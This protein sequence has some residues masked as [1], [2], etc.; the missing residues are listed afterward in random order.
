MTD[1]I[2]GNSCNGQTYKGRVIT[3]PIYAQSS[4]RLV[5]GQP[6]AGELENLVSTKTLSTPDSRLSNA[7]YSFGKSSNGTR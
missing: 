4:T 7:L 3:N 2:G 6:G 1:D 5:V